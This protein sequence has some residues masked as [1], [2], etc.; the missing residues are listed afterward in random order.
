MYFFLKKKYYYISRILSSSDFLILFW[1]AVN[2]YICPTSTNA[3]D[4][5]SSSSDKRVSVMC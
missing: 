3:A 4:P 5:A 1:V 2:G